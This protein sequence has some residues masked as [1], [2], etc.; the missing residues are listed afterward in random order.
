MTPSSRE[1]QVNHD[2]HPERLLQGTQRRRTVNDALGDLLAR[3]A[4]PDPP[5]FD[6]EQAHIVG[7]LSGNA[8]P[9]NLGY[10]L[11]K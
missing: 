11:A 6:A 3:I 4:D 8:G 1:R 5:Q 10:D 9:L 2:V 7:E